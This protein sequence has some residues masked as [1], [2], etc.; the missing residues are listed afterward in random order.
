MKRTGARLDLCVGGK[1]PEQLT[2][3]LH[4]NGLGE[5]GIH[6]A[7]KGTLDI[8]VKD[9]G[10]D[11]HNGNGS[12]VLPGQGA[13]GVSGCQTVH[14]RRGQYGVADGRLLSSSTT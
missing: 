10:A 8:L 14:D 1:L 11:S 2:E 13:D 5:M 3:L 6:A 7:G 4:L 9:V 12:A